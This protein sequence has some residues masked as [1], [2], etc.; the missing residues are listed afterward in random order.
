MIVVLT[1]DFGFVEGLTMRNEGWFGDGNGKVLM[2]GERRLKVMKL[3][4]TRE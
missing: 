1:E 2:D 3:E 4:A